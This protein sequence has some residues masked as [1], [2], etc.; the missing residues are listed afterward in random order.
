MELRQLA[1]FLTAAQ[2]QNFRQAA[3]R[4][5]VAQ[6]SLS[7]Q[8]AALERELGIELFQ[9]D[10]KRVYLTDAGEEFALYVR[11]AFDQLQQGQKA[12]DKVREG[13]AGTIRLGCVEPLAAAFLPFILPRFHA[14]HPRIHVRVRVNR[15]DE[16]LALLTH[17]ELDLGLIFDPDAR[18]D[19]LVVQELFR[20]PLRLLVSAQHP[21]ASSPPASLTL[22]RITEQQLYTLGETSR[23]RRV[24]D[25]I[26]IQRG[27]DF[28][29]TIEIDSVEGLKELVRLGD[30]VTLILPALLHTGE[31]EDQ[32]RL[33]PVHGLSDEFIFALVYK[34]TGTLP[35]AARQLINYL[36]HHTQPSSTRP[37][38]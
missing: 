21:L 17:G 25:R 16:L 29:P 32:L 11:R 15:T 27:L 23:L 9:R 6:P 36:Q 8:I 22:E 19:V 31:P 30:G 18:S 26:F 5:L 4:C 35:L 24:I 1:Y 12:L 7:R 20:Q 3:E 37:D 34:R 33:L 28:R 2:T 10:R 13:Q 14:K 38:A